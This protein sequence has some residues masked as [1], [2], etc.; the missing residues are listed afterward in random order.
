[1]VLEISDGLFYS[2]VVGDLN[3]EPDPCRNHHFG[4]IWFG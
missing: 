2:I 1:M 3:A 4:L